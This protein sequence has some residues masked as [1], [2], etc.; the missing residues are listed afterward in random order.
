MLKRYATMFKIIAAAAILIPLPIIAFVMH[1]GGFAHQLRELS[2]SLEQTRTQDLSVETKLQELY[3]ALDWVKRELIKVPSQKIQHD[4]S[5]FSWNGLLFEPSFM[6]FCDCLAQPD[7]CQ[8][9]QFIQ[10]ILIQVDAISDEFT[11]PDDLFFDADLGYL[12]QAW[13]IKMHQALQANMKKKLEDLFNR[14]I[15]PKVLPA[16]SITSAAKT[17]PHTSE[18]SARTSGVDGASKSGAYSGQ[19]YPDYSSASHDYSAGRYELAGLQQNPSSLQDKGETEAE[20]LGRK[21]RSSGQPSHDSSDMMDEVRS[22]LGKDNNG[23][24]GNLNDM[25]VGKDAD[26]A[27]KMKFSLDDMRERQKKYE[28]IRDSAMENHKQQSFQNIKR[29]AIE[30]LGG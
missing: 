4:K 13:Q 19:N 9:Q 12:A 6:L 28:I 27:N 21:K 24:S 20:A 7:T 1:R 22:F 2:A 11:Q 18:A 29:N 26:W 25:F 16:A 17:T 30:L 14:N 8:H 3:K 15:T 23:K 5:Q 10:K